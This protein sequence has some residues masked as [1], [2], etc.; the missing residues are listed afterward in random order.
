MKCPQGQVKCV[1]SRLRYQRRWLR[2]VTRGP[3]QLPDCG[4][5]GLTERP[6]CIHGGLCVGGNR[7]KWGSRASWQIDHISKP[8]YWRNPTWLCLYKQL[9]LH[10]GPWGLMCPGASEWEDLGIRGQ[11]T[12]RLPELSC[13]RDLYCTCILCTY[14]TYILYTLVYIP[15]TY[16]Y[17]HTYICVQYVYVYAYFFTLTEF[18]PQRRAQNEINGAVC[19]W[20]LSG[21]VCVG[22]FGWSHVC[23]FCVRVCLCAYWEHMLS[24]TTGWTQGHGTVAALSLSG[25]GIQQLPDV[26]DWLQPLTLFSWKKCT[27]YPEG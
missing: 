21:F 18:H 13:W 2:E 4:A 16:I 9:E 11:L 1:S 10:Y 5:G 12:G 22:L 27:V 6:V 7:R 23:V 8:S 3:R 26:Q 24:L 17:V 20:V 15:H 19:I 14:N 25:S